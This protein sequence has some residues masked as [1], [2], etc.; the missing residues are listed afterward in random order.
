MRQ[1]IK[2][3]SLLIGCQKRPIHSIPAVSF[4]GPTILASLMAFS[5]VIAREAGDYIVATSMTPPEPCQVHE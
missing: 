5:V 2:Q 4:L 1:L 3:I